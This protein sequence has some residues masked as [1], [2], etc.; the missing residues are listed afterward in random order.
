MSNFMKMCFNK[1]PKIME[2]VKGFCNNGAITIVEFTDPYL[3]IV[4][5]PQVATPDSYNN[6]L[7]KKMVFPASTEE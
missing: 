3:L 1:H 7:Q 6:W 4:R 2:T 5:T